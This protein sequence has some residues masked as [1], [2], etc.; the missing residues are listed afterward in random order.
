M[1]LT[2]DQIRKRRAGAV[3]PK[4]QSSVVPQALVLRPWERLEDQVSAST[5]DNRGQTQTN[6][7]SRTPAL[8]G[9]AD[10]LAPSAPT[11]EERL[12]SS[13][14]VVGQTTPPAVLDQSTGDNR[15]RTQTNTPSRTPALD[16]G[17]DS[18]APSAPTGEERLQSSS[19][20]VGQTRAP[21]SPR[22]INRGQQGTNT[23]E[24]P[25]P[26]ARTRRRC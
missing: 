18:L 8:D 14:S 4:T 11:G 10:S 17:A 12:E 19:F 24:H 25:I 6:S 21:R 5:G 9:G 15:G 7:P 13:S 16:G 22:S 2:L 26:D 20:V 3:L 23:D 1:A